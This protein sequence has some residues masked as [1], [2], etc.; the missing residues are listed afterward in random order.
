[1]E[2][3]QTQLTKSEEQHHL[4][5]KNNKAFKTIKKAVEFLRFNT[6]TSIK[7]FKEH[8]N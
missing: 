5:N 3:T 6:Q 4:K 1:M 7:T 2:D 8:Q